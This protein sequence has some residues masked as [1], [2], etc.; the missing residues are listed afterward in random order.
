MSKTVL[1]FPGQAS[2]YVGM[3]KE[4]YES[5]SDV[6][7]L[8]EFASNE[9]NYDIARLSFEGPSDEL[10]RTRF[11]QPAILLHSLAVLTVMGNRLPAFDFAAGHSL[12]EYGALAV[13]GAMTYNQAVKAVIKRAELMEDAC[14]KRPGTM[15]AIM[16]LKADKAQDICN[17]ASSAGI[18]IPANYNSAIQ[19]VISGEVVGVEKAVELAREAKAKRAVILKVG[20]AFHSPLM[21]SSKT[22]LEKYLA[23]QTYQAPSR[24]VVANVTA[25][26]VTTA[27]AICPLLVAQMT[28]PVMW[29]QTMKYLVE[30]GVN[31]VYEI[32]PGKVLSGLARRDMRPEKLVNLDTLT[33]IETFATSE[34][35]L[36]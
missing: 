21:E 4:L 9:M 14:I 8:Y 35:G 23:Q 19:I 18:V 12:G 17:Q 33:D 22:G 16:G 31:A 2:Q 10:K 20:G 29:A 25:Q 5:S 6:R 11:T 26:S 1:F 34:K 36:V 3:G 24:P 32:G 27:E 7:M 30:Q 28:S 13:T 15:A